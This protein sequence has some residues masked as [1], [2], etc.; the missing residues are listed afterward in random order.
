[1]TAGELVQIVLTVG[2]LL[3]VARVAFANNATARRTFVGI[4]YLMLPLLFWFTHTAPFVLPVALNGAAYE[5]ATAIRQGVGFEVPVVVLLIWLAGS[6]LCLGRTLRQLA[7]S[8]CWLRQL[9][10]LDDECDSAPRRW[11]IALHLDVSRALGASGRLPLLRLGSQ[12]CSSTLFGSVLVIPKDLW[13]DFERTP[14]SDATREC[15][16]TVLSHE[17]VHIMRRDDAWLLL[18]R[19]LSDVLWWVPFS[20][21]LYRRFAQDVEASCDDRASDLFSPRHSYLTGLATA[22]RIQHR[23][24]RASDSAMATAG[25]I[26]GELITRVLRLASVNDADRSLPTVAML[27]ALLVSALLVGTALHPMPRRS[28]VGPITAA[29]LALNA[30]RPPDGARVPE[31]H[32]TV[33]EASSTEPLSYVARHFAEDPRRARPFYP[34]HAL[35][36]RLEGLVELEFELHSDGSVGRAQVVDS[37]PAGVFD[38]AVLNAVTAQRVTPIP[39]H[40]HSQLAWANAREPL[41]VRQRFR[42]RLVP[43]TP[44]D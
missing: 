3:I 9:P 40:F 11:V 17:T 12:A 2:L 32:A 8:R 37:R 10:R 36:A 19:L 21:P 22:A 35:E 6:V 29:G 20:R 41:R 14:S 33:I 42:F 7:R 39:A 24:R 1:M 30:P 43:L 16:R 25:L 4:G 15:L 23:V 5:L 31:V 26:A 13:I 18:A 44:R 28:P 27:H 34:A 38:Q